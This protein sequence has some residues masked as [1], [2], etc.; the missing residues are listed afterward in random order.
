MNYQTVTITKEN[1]VGILTLNRPDKLNAVDFTMMEE[2]PAALEELSSDRQIRVLIITGSGRGFCAGADV[3]ATIDKTKKEKSIWDTGIGRSLQG[4]RS[5][6]TLVLGIR[7]APVPVIAAVN[8]VAAGVGLSIALACDIRIASDKARFSMAFVKMGLVPDNGGSYFL[9]RLIGLGQAAE[10]ILTGK[11][12]EAQEADRIGI[13]NRVVPH[14]SLM[15]AARDLAR[16][17]AGNPPLTVKAA[18]WA[19]YQGMVAPDLEEHIKY[20]SGMNNLLLETEDQKEAVKAY[21]E[22][23]PPQFKGQ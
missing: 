21:F 13:V 12:I 14:E 2:A 17:I 6:M 5:L 15:E 9:P 18:R 19:L 11:I 4:Q 22:K 8:G 10:L 20:E 3:G 16:V 1:N 7:N 23:R